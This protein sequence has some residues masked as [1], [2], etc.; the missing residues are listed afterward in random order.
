MAFSFSLRSM[1]RRASV[2][3]INPP[4]PA[5]TIGSSVFNWRSI[6]VGESLFILELSMK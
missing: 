1:E 6:R 4:A 3:A 2:P 5:M